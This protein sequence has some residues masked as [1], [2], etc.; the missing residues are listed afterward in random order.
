M[1]QSLFRWHVHSSGY[2]WAKVPPRDIT[3]GTGEFAPFLRPLE[4]ESGLRVYQ[5]MTPTAPVIP[6]FLALSGSDNLRLSIREFANKYGPL[7][8]D[9]SC[10]DGGHGE[11]LS[12]W[13]T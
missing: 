11:L 12:D 6:R 1:A 2:G 7:G 5:P 13:K 4:P 8:I 9:R 10:I 3:E